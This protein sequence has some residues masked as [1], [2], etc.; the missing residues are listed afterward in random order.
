[1]KMNFIIGSIILLLACKNDNSSIEINSSELTLLERI[2][3]PKGYD[4]ITEER[5][6]FGEFL[7]NTKLKRLGAKF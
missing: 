5:G 4:W 7:Q 6:S 3:A 2:K 1:M